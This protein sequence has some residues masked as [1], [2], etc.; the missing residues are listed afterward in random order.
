M[1]QLPIS[2]QKVSHFL[3]RLPGIGEKTANRL[4][5]HLLRL[6]DEDL[7]VFGTAVTQ[8][9]SLIKRCRI[10]QNLCEGD[11][12]C[13][14][15]TDTRRDKTLITVVES[16]LDVVSFETGGIY[17]GVYH[18]LHGKI[19]P[20]NRVS[21]DHLTIEQLMI[22]ITTERPLEIIL[23]T[24]PDMEGEATAMYIRHQI[25]EINTTRSL[26]VKVS[27]LAYGLPMGGNVEYADYVTLRKAM[28]GRSRM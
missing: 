10:C 3:T 18:V 20:L 1:A 11:E 28:E 9:K 26:T 25:Q 19:D 16:V 21:P 14:I 5:F 4:A 6:P 7:Q 13:T 24:N 22:R 17:E 8:L 27:R 12:L 23:A 15:C 2:L